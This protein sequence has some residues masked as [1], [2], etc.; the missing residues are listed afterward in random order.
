VCL[1]KQ[2][3]FLGL[4]RLLCLQTHLWCIC[5][6][7]RESSDMHEAHKKAPQ[8]EMLVSMVTMELFF[9]IVA[10]CFLFYTWFSWKPLCTQTHR[11]ISLPKE[12]ANREKRVQQSAPGPSSVQ[13]I[14]KRKG[15]SA[16]ARLILLEDNKFCKGL[17]RSLLN[18]IVFRY[19][20]SIHGADENNLQ[21]W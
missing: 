12:N 9:P 5:Y 1:L 10:L 18:F 8:W 7:T 14:F 17:L 11:H 6:C 19:S 15:F 2:S 13:L 20:R 16:Q 4:L 3:V 21:G